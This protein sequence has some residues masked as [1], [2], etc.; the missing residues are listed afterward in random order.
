[1][2]DVASVVVVAREHPETDLVLAGCFEREAPDVEGLP[3]EVSSAVERLA[4]RGGWTGKD[5]QVAQAEVPGGPVVSLFGL[6]K[7]NDFSFQ[8]LARW[9]SR[10]SEHARVGGDRRRMFL[11]PRHG[12]T[13][14]AP[15]AERILRTIAL[16]T[17]SYDRFQTQKEQPPRPEALTVA[18]PLGE[19]ETYRAAAPFAAEVAAA[20]ETARDLANT[21]PNE[22]TPAWMEERAR[23][24]AAERG[25]EAT[26]LD[27]DEL[28]RRGM[29]GILAV[30]AGA[31]V[32][33][34]LVKLSWGESGPVL[35]LVG[36]G[37]TFDTGGISIKP[38]ADMDEMKYDK[39][40]A[41]AVLA[42]ARAIAGLGLPVRLRAY[43]PL[44]ENMPGSRAYRPGDI[45]RMA[46]GKTV[47]ITNTDAEGRLIL[48]DALA[49][50]VEE[51]AEAIVELST[52][53]GHCVVA[54]GHLAGGLFT[55]DEAF[56][57]ELLAASSAAGERLWRLPLF[58]EH[59]DEMK[60]T[61]ADLKNA[62][63]RP[64]GASTAAAFLSEFV[65][66]LTSWAHLDI[67]GTSWLKT[68]K[69]GEPAGA[70]GFGVASVVSWVRR[71]AVS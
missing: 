49:L 54:L 50:A 69:D 3:H 66:G 18:P 13:T 20:V 14:G 15:A 25:L 28:E 71:R 46:N 17:Y 67:A 62:A 70:T 26:V 39:A 29:G 27:V 38:A 51:G 1:M 35:A 55:P 47:E 59:T 5:D 6:G 43:A 42:A 60:G 37:V 10:A 52:L 19:E 33:P 8:K 22:A 24:L 11:L 40:G 56:A 64:G 4:A 63:G 31:V 16:S 12:E 48:A 57:D 34:R 53:T 7:R 23:E 68:E 30:G 65:G 58:P 9:I 61:H 41:C 32:P 21:P 44:A 2:T 36:K 45:L